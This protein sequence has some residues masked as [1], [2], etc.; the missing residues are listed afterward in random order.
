MSLIDQILLDIVVQAF[1]EAS[2]T[3][4]SLDTPPR[5]ELG[6][7]ALG[8]F[9]L[10]KT[11]RLAPP[12]I[13]ERL[14]GA[15]RDRAEYF[16]DVTILGGYVNFF[17]TAQAWTEL[18]SDLSTADKPA[19]NETIVVD[20]IGANTGK[21]LHIGHICTPS[22]GQT[23]INTHKH[24]GYTVISDSHFGDWGGIFG[25]LIIAYREDKSILGDEVDKKLEIEGVNYLLWLYQ[26]FFEKIQ[27]P[28]I[29]DGLF[30]EKDFERDARMEFQY[31]SGV[32][33]NL[34]NQEERKHHE[35]NVEL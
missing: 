12:I 29:E 33:I 31:L 16:R 20:Y 7:F 18:L 27:V 19:R 9:P 25:K 24:L 32:G 17:L 35:E 30:T 15:I 14:A 8:V 1:P 5:N 3:Q 4:L 22:I 21:P 34:D 23:I 2:G 11:T 28:L 13:A 26:W 10:A 6:N